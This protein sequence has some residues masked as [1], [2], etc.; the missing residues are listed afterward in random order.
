M[1]IKDDGVGFDVNKKM[2]GIGLANM[3][4]RAMLFKGDFNLESSPNK[5]C[6][7]SIEIP[8]QENIK[9]KIKVK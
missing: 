5:G 1:N 8:I 9:E 6:Q 3:K 4:R 7:V 2:K